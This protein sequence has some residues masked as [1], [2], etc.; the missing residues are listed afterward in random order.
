MKDVKVSVLV[1]ICN[2]ERYLR[3]CLRTLERQTLQEMEF[4]CVNDGSTDG[5]LKILQRFARRDA[6]FR[7]ID[8][9]NTGYG[10]SMNLALAQAVGEYIGIVEPDDYVEVDTFAN[11]YY[12][13]KK[14]R[15]DVVR[16][17]YFEFGQG[18]SRIVPQV[19][20]DESAHKFKNAL[21]E[22]DAGRRGENF[23]CLRQPPAIW[24]GLYK[25]AF[26]ERDQIHFLPTPGASYQDTGFFWKTM[27]SAKKI[28]FTIEPY[29]HYRTDNAN[30]S[31]KNSAKVDMVRK[32]YHNIVNYLQRHHLYAE[33]AGVMQATK[34]ATYYWNLLRLS[35]ELTRKFLPKMQDEFKLAWADDEL[36]K[37]NFSR[38]HWWALQLLLHARPLFAC[39]LKIY[40]GWKRLKNR[41]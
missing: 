36:E 20:F 25:R 17:N 3:E 32:E 18:Y 5:S 31:V 10:D 35:P 28:T 14:E 39:Q 24:S 4:I 33:F 40:R 1:P 30:S 12:L 38:K 41:T 11:L 21:A 7:V 13:A 27:A 34:F 15:A 8:K 9:E 19:S 26:L 29:Y 6:R 23:H 37:R 22:K 16:A 2:V